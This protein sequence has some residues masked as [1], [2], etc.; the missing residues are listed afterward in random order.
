MFFNS[1]II[2]SSTIKSLEIVVSKIYR[3]GIGKPEAIFYV[4]SSPWHISQ[5][6]V[7]RLEKN[8]PFIFTAKLANSLIQKEMA[9]LKEEYLSD[10]IV[11]M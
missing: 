11:R 2:L 3:A 9:L 5:T 1:N 7:I 10:R 6:R 4:L 8:A